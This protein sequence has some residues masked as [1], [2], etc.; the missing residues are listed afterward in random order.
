[1]KLVPLLFILCACNDAGSGSA[2]GAV[3]Q[4][5]F[6]TLYADY[7]QNCKNCHTPSG[8]GRTSDIEQNLDFTSVGT[9]FTTITTMSAAGLMGNFSGCNGTPFIDADP[10]NS[11]IIAVLDQPTRVAFDLP[12]H[13]SCN[14]DSISDETAKVGSAPSSVFI[15]NLKTWINDGAPNN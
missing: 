12:S 15:A 14:M 11:L 13:A 1:M 3:A 10:A 6:T 4:A 5:T 9:A 2:D 8:P 7:F